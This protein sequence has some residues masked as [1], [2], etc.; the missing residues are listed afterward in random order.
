[1]LWGR[2]ARQW[3]PLLGNEFAAQ[4]VP[5]QDVRLKLHGFPESDLSELVH[6]Y[7]V[8]T[9]RSNPGRSICEH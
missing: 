7:H 3:I 2:A 4:H 9:R 5:L 6:G 1:M 8:A